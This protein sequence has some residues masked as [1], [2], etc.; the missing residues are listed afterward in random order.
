MYVKTLTLKGAPHLGGR[1]GMSRSSRSTVVVEKR[2]RVVRP[3]GNAAPSGTAR[4]TGQP[5]SGSPRPQL[6]Q[7]SAPPRSG[8]GLSA[9]EADARA[10]VLRQAEARQ[11]EDKERF[12]ADEARCHLTDGT[13]ATHGHHHVEP[14]SNCVPRQARGVALTGGLADFCFPTF[15]TQVRQ[16]A[17]EVVIDIALACHGAAHQ[18]HL[19]VSS[20]VATAPLVHT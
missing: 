11:A 14:V 2:T 8:G 16:Y 13:I 10:R 3:T 4:P 18:K 15:A 9:T 1:A 19:H 7:P 17:R 5:S 20:L 12:A 6:R